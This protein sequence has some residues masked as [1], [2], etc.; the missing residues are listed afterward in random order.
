[1]PMTFLKPREGGA[2]RSPRQEFEA[3]Q[4]INQA[5]HET[6]D[7]GVVLQRIIAETVP[8][9]AAQS[10][11]VI[12]H[13][14]ATN[15]AE[16]T[17]TYGQDAS[18]HTLRY[19]LPGSLTGWVAAHQRPLRVPRLTPQ[20]WPAVWKIAEQLGAVPAQVSVLLVPLRV[21]GKVIGS[22]EVV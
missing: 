11:S 13:D 10:G 15:E 5:L 2:T 3:L 20:E 8:L 4:R 7:L 6:L 22:L 19:P 21:Q 18:S 17:T 9:L 14:D 16:L 12:L 1:M